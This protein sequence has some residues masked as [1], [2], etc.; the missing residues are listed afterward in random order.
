MHIWFPIQMES[1]SG[2]DCEV[3]ADFRDHARHRL[4]FH[5]QYS[6]GAEVTAIE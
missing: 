3:N 6:V 5:P 1:R 2:P 4:G